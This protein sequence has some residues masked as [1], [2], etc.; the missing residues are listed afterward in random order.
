MP[1]VLRVVVVGQLCQSIALCRYSSML[2]LELFSLLSV[3]FPLS[4]CSCGILLAAASQPGRVSGK[5]RLSH[6]F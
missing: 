1:P 2:T 4:Y 3:C 5:L 6:V